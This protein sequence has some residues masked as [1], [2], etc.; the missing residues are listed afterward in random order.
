MGGGLGRLPFRPAPVAA[1]GFTY[2]CA[3]PKVAGMGNMSGPWAGQLYGNQPGQL[4]A[5]LSGEPEALEG[6]LSRH[7]RSG[8]VTI[9]SCMGRMDG[10]RVELTC[11]AADGALVLLRG[12]VGGEGQVTG[13]WSEGDATPDQFVLFPASRVAGQAQ[14]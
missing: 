12:T 14:A 2:A 8:D 1:W 13:T 10:G 9:F 11:R 4:Y 5:E 7:G 3:G 6:A